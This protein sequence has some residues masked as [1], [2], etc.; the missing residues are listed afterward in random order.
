VHYIASQDGLLKLVA[1][2]AGK[3]R[4]SFGSARKVVEAL[5]TTDRMQYIAS[6][7]GLNSPSA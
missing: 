4:G 6:Q 1:G 5:L 7:S 2:M 3:S